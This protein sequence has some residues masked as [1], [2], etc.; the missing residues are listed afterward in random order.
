MKVSS[1]R[2]VFAKGDVPGKIGPDV[3]RRVD[4]DQLDPALPLNL[5]AQRPVLQARQNQL[6]VPPDQLALNKRVGG[7]PLSCRPR[8]STENKSC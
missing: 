2:V 6:V 5:L 7:Q 3:E 8:S 4:V 1:P